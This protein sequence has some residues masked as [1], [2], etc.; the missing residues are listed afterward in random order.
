MVEDPHAAIVDYFIKELGSED[1]E[2]VEGLQKLIRGIISSG[3]Y[4]DGP[5]FRMLIKETLEY[6]KSMINY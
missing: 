5:A 2:E 6:K 1:K 4:S 3:N